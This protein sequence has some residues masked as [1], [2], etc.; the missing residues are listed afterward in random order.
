[1]DHDNQTSEQFAEW[2]AA[3]YDSQIMPKDSPPEWQPPPKPAKPELI[4][5]FKAGLLLCCGVFLP[6]IS[7]VVE[8][9]TSMCAQ[10]MFDPLPTP[11][12]IFLVAFVPA[13]NWF[14]W[15]ALWHGKT[16]YLSLLSV[17]SAATIGIAAFYTLVF[18]PIMPFAVIAIIIFGLGILPLTPILALLVTIFGRQK[19]K[20]LNAQT[21]GVRIPH[22][23]LGFGLGLL[24]LIA[25]ELPSAVTRIGLQMASS[26]DVETSRRG[27]QWLRTVGSQDVMLRSCY[28]AQQGMTDLVSWFIAQGDPVMQDDARRIYYRVTGTPFNAVRP[29][30]KL[31]RKVRTW[32]DD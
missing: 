25:A 16:E 5:D 29:P 20:R 21:V 12:H 1:M 23:L 9:T 19:L 24:G 10:D 13:S 11:F 15:R 17:T 31:N 8:L 27:V 26:P 32:G 28:Q 4:S 30:S 2:K 6:I 7:F 18:L 3:S 22:L 14:L